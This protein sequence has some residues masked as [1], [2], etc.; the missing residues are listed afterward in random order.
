MPQGNAYAHFM[1][2]ENVL[3]GRILVNQNDLTGCWNLVQE[4]PSLWYWY[5]LSYMQSDMLA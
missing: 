3:L 4:R 2:I 1:Q 5:W